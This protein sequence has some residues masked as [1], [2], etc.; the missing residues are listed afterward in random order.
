MDNALGG[1]GLP[2]TEGALIKQDRVVSGAIQAIEH[3]QARDATANDDRIKAKLG[4][5]S[6]HG[7]KV[8]YRRII[9]AAQYTCVAGQTWWNC[10]GRTVMVEQGVSWYSAR[11][12]YTRWL[13]T[14][15]FILLLPVIALRLLWRSLKAP[16]YRRRWAERFGIF[17]TP[18][19]PSTSIWIHTVSVG[20][21]LAAIPLIKALQTKYPDTPLVITTTTP[22]GSARAKA[23]FADQIQRQQILHVYAPYDIPW[24]IN[25][26]LQRTRPRLL[27]IMETELW[28]NLVSIC[29]TK[30]IP[31]VLANARLSEKSAR[32]YQRF[33]ALTRN[34]LKQ[35]DHVAAQNISDGDRFVQLGLDKNRLLITGS[36]KFDLRLSPEIQQQAHALRTIWSQHEQRLIWLAASTHPGEDEIVLEVFL[37]LKKS[38]P[39]LLLV[40]V[41]RHPERFDG[42]YRLCVDTK[43]SVSR[44]S[45]AK[46]ANQ[47]IDIILGDT[48]GELLVFYGVCDMAFVGGS[49]V[50]V[51]GHNMI[52]P[53]V[54]GKAI[55]SGNHLH[56]FADVSQLLANHGAIS[57]CH[58]AGEL[59]DS[60]HQLLVNKPKRLFMGEQAKILAEQNRGAL[61]KLMSLIDRVLE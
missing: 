6:S 10:H 52:E 25:G 16:D 51:G 9:Q 46:N 55:I 48:M 27:I 14:L 33:A 29:S 39:N 15:C 28:P 61:E 7:E 41:P 45:V 35:I 17:P 2:F 38:F 20:E 53:A 60:A 54:W 42:V 23:V 37:Q 12:M 19:W 18:A 26:F 4:E 13:Y 43:L 30:R 49:L 24:A 31:V 32:G 36:I 58:N 11:R 5:W 21:F 3:P 47:H 40:L 50:P 8:S 22:T 56:N 1:Y 34:M 57:I 44:H 59:L